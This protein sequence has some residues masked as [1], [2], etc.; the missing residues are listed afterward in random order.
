M[1]IFSQKFK[2]CIFFLNQFRA[3]PFTFGGAAV[4]KPPETE[5]KASTEENDEDEPP[6]PDF[7]PVTEEGS[8][9]EQK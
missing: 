2:N 3:K 5:E 8:V 4:Q 6:K 9:F 1:I 7:K